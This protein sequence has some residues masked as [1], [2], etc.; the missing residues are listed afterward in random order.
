M[1]SIMITPRKSAASRPSVPPPV[2]DGKRRKAR[3]G[4]GGHQFAFASAM[5]SLVEEDEE[6]GLAPTLPTFDPFDA[7]HNPALLWGNVM[8]GRFEPEPARIGYIRD[9]EDE[10]W[11]TFEGIYRPRGPPPPRVALP[12]SAVFN[13][14]FASK[15]D[16]HND[17]VLKTYHMSDEDYAAL[18]TWLYAEGWYVTLEER[19]V[20]EVEPD[21]L[22]SRRWI[23]PYKPSRFE[24]AAASAASEEEPTSCCSAPA[25][26]PVAPRKCI[27]RFCKHEEACPLK[28]TTCNYTHGPSIP[29]VDKPCGFD[30]PEEG[31]RC[32]GDKR[33]TC[34]FMHP[35]EGQVWNASM[36]IHRPKA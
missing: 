24:L 17:G 12:Y 11:T 9:S 16:E 34:I 6:E 35:S 10:P 28:D 1:T 26:K 29:C 5:A 21:T 18:M 25:P 20:V 4:G 30:K 33:A 22:P 36:V 14:P 27:P 2:G 15:L 19:F 13:Q 3:R 8:E 32:S 31:K 7:L 23:P